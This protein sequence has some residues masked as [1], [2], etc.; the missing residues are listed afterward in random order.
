MVGA[1]GVRRVPTNFDK[2][3]R[4]N[5]NRFARQNPTNLRLSLDRS[6]SD[7]VSQSFQGKTDLRGD[8]EREGEGRKGS[9]SN[10]VGERGEERERERKGGKGEQ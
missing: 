8:I 9:G 1:S 5:F 4:Q 3:M 2:E 10:R 7:G 6:E